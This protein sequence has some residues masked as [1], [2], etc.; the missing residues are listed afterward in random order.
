MVRRSV[1]QYLLV[2]IL[3][4]LELAMKDELEKQRRQLDALKAMDYDSDDS[5]STVIT[6]LSNISDISSNISLSDDSSD[7]SS[8]DSDLEE[9]FSD[10]RKLVELY[11]MVQQKRYSVPRTHVMGRNEKLVDLLDRHATTNTRLYRGLV[12]M[13]PEA[14]DNLASRLQSTQ[15]FGSGSLPLR[16]V[17]EIVSV[18]LYR[19]GRSGNGGGERDAS[20]QCGCSV[21]SLIGWTD[22]T[23]EGLL[24]LNKEV[25]R[26]ASKGE[27]SRAKA[28][29]RN[30]SGADEWGRGWLP[31]SMQDSRVWTTGS[32]ILKKPRLYLDEGEFIWVDGGY[33]FSP[34]TCGPYMHINADKSRD[35]KYFNNKLSQ[36]RVRVEHAIAYLKNRFQCLSGY[37]GNIYRVNDLEAAGKAIQACIIAHTFASRYDKPDDLAEL[38]MLTEDDANE[39]V[40][41]PMPDPVHDQQV[42]RQR[43]ANQRQYEADQRLN[44][45]SSLVS[46]LSGQR[47]SL[48]HDLREEMFTSLFAATDR[49]PVD[50]TAIL[51]RYEQTAAAWARRVAPPN[52]GDD[53]EGSD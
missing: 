26:F 22:R 24:E 40:Q 39:V 53:Q 28:W 3:D 41:A 35:L 29:V 12:R 46:A 38:L 19:L 14:F 50:T 27:R 44:S 45:Q 9:P 13:T 25:M 23:I 49:T 7:D 4:A 34:F 36:V 31:G 48:G 1:K 33:G 2:D 15:A 47:V 18:A 43:R 32:N 10:S 20:L 6:D 52:T 11:T 16:K 8:A 21:G 17:R 42:Q 51:R 30:T 37:R 5:A